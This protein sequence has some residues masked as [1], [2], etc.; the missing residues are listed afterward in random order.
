VIDRYI[1][2]V[3][4]DADIAGAIDVFGNMVELVDSN[5]EL[6][7]RYGQECNPCRASSQARCLYAVDFA[8]QQRILGYR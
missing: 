7:Q 1:D 6:Q 3:E 5:G 8:V 2:P 4:L